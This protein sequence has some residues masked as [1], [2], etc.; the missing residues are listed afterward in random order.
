MFDK[1]KKRW[2]EIYCELLNT[3]S[4]AGR[5]ALLDEAADLLKFATDDPDVV[6]ES[7]IKTLMGDVE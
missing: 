6:I 1:I 4:T 5:L 2:G 3:P 7:G